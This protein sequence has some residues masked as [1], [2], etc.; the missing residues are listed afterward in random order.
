MITLA[1]RMPK[2]RVKR[3]WKT[4]FFGLLHNNSVQKNKAY[5]YIW[6][7]PCNMYNLSQLH[8]NPQER[9]TKL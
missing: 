3:K 1:N 9:S 8:I 2:S 7:R 4:S 5:Q 6:Q